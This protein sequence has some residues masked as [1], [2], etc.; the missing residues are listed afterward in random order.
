VTLAG[1]YLQ[2]DPLLGRSMNNIPNEPSPW[3]IFVSA[4]ILTD[5]GAV[6]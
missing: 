6:R 2:L 3:P 5:A 4:D 1:V